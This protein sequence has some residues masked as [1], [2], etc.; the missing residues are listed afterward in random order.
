M[1]KEAKIFAYQDR[2]DREKIVARSGLVG[3]FYYLKNLVSDHLKETLSDDDA[4]I[5]TKFVNNGG[6]ST[7]S[8]AAPSVD[9][10]AGLKPSD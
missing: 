8:L 10:M 3:Y 9:S 5:L 7:D 6:V 1:L 2:E 4:K